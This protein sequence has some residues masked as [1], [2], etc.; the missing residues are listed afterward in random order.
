MIRGDYWGVTRAV[1]YAIVMLIL[2]PTLF[3]GFNILCMSGFVWFMGLQN[4][5]NHF[6]FWVLLLLAGGTLI[7]CVKYIATFIATIF[8]NLVSKICPIW[9]YKFSIRWAIILCTLNI[10]SFVV[11][12]WLDNNDHGLLFWIFGIELVWLN[13]SFAKGIIVTLKVFK[14]L[15]IEELKYFG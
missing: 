11:H 14:Q 4:K 12:Y 6:I 5:L 9:Y 2:I 1:I 3:S 8:V 13:Y 15:Q 10:I 7:F